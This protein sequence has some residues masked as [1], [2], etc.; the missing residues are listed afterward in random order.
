MNVDWCWQYSSET[1]FSNDN[2]LTGVQLYWIR[3]H[4]CD[5][6]NCAPAMQVPDLFNDES[7]YRHN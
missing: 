3:N 2:E 1:L 4:T 5:K 7:D 6:E